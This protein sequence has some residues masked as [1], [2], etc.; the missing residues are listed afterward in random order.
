MTDREQ[1]GELLREM[2]R[3]ARV[4]R[5]ASYRYRNISGTKVGILQRLKH[6]DA[7]LG[8]LARQLGISAPVATRAVH[9]LESDGLV[10]RRTDASDARASLISLTDHGRETVAERERHIAERFAQVLGD[11]GPEQTAQALDVLQ[12]LNIHL[13]ELTEILETNDRGEPNA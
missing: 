2:V 8:D 10:E 1:A 4:F 11:W 6:C 12:Q 5:V 13:D 7:R 3:I 9:A